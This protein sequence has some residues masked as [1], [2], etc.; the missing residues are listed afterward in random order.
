MLP[1]TRQ[2]S[3]DAKAANVNEGQEKP[4]ARLFVRDVSINRIMTTDPATV[5][6]NDSI[7]VATQ[8]LESGDIH[9]LPVIENGLL[10]GI[11]SSSDL[12]KFHLLTSDPAAVPAGKVRQI[13]EPDPVVLDSGASLRDAATTLSVG[14]YHALPVVEQD[15]ELVGI[16]TTVDLVT[17]LL[18]QIPR[19]DG[20]LHEH[21][22][23]DSPLRPSDNEIS[24][25]VS[26]AEEV[27]GQGKDTDGSAR[28]LLHF[29]HQNRLLEH[30]RK[31]AELYLRSGHGEHEH[32]V[33]VKR[34][35]DI[36]RQ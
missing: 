20:S 19:D 31:A 16:V 21:A 3:P 23:A 30:V 28:V 29:R 17:H 25:L 4:N 26:L 2:R 15:R 24:R 10:A 9:H 6:V 1:K 22:K 7:S 27:A 18:Q 32:S 13:M 8:L 5:D 14:G 35:A 36:N 34:L 12:L 11:L 33:L